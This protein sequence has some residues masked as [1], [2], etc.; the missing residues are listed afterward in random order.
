MKKTATL[1]VAALMLVL[2]ACG[3]DKNDDG[4]VGEPVTTTTT[5][6][7]PTTTIAG[8]A[9]IAMWPAAD[10]VFATPEAAARDFVAKVLDVPPSLGE[11]RQGDARSGEIDVFSPGEGGTQRIKR[12]TLVLRQL[13]AK[14]G[15]F[16]I[17]AGSDG[18]S[19][20][21]LSTGDTVSP[22]KVTV[23]GKARGFEGN[24]VVRGYVAGDDVELGKVVTQGGSMADTAPYKVSLDLTG[25]T[26]GSTVFIVVRGGVG[27]ETDP[28]EFA[29]VPLRVR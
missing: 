23:E 7:Q 21:N 25:A 2:G 16:V 27:L 10:A 24:V 20:T 1:L 26:S 15:W 6:S 8:V 28:G 22:G 11:F 12:A 3:G 19:I 4:T 9:A 29:A 14:N 5:Q 18:A 13:G 17:S